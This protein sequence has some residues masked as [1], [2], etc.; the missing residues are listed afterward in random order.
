MHLD[1]QTLAFIPL[2]LVLTLTP[3]A[4]TLLVVRNALSRGRASGVATTFG[5]CSGLFIHA[6]VSALGLSVIVLQS[7]LAYSLLKYAGAAYIVYLGIRSLLRKPGPEPG[8]EP[9]HGDPA[10]I[11]SSVE[12]GTSRRF[13]SPLSRSLAEGFLCNVLNPKVVVFYLAILPQFV[14]PTDPVLAKSLLLT[15]IHFAMGLVWLVVLSLF[16]GR[17][18]AFISGDRLRHRLEKVSGAIFVGLGLKMALE[19]R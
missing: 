19:G 15:A 17:M 9:G 10:R 4:D 13:S 6:L 11:P 2:A 18:R 14:S 1:P 5:I 16:L 12:F 8:D 7:A 3:G